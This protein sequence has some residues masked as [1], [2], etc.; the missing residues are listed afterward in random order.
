MGK[1]PSTREVQQAAA[2]PRIDRKRSSASHLQSD[3]PITRRAVSAVVPGSKDETMSN[4]RAAK[5]V[6]TGA[7]MVKKQKLQMQAAKPI[8][9]LLSDSDDDFQ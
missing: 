6:A 8:K 2:V 5:L 1:P 3:S 9:N 4:P 7:L